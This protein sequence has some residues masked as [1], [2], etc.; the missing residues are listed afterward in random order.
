[1]GSKQPRME[2]ELIKISSD[3]A[4]DISWWLSKMISVICTSPI[5][6][7]DLPRIVDL[8]VLFPASFYLPKTEFV[9]PR[10]GKNTKRCRKLEFPYLLRAARVG[11]RV[12]RIGF[13]AAHVRSC[14]ARVLPA[15]LLWTKLQIGITH[16]P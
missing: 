16:Y 6:I 7:C 1:L 12:A 13:R 10:Y 4:I 8:V 14:A 9:W 15:F 3:M 5:L 11:F 2:G